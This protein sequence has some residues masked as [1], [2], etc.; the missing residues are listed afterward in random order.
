MRKNLLTVAVL[1]VLPALALAGGYSV[2]NVTPADLAMAGSRMAA[3]DS[4][5]AVFVNPAALPRLQGL[6]LSLAGALIDIKS[7]WSDPLGKQGPVDMETNLV[8]VPA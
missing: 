3:Q 5:G 1:M 2:P 4:A 6:N 7:Q 8:P